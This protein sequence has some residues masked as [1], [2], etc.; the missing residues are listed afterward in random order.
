MTDNETV[1][2]ST[3]EHTACAAI[4]V[5]VPDATEEG[6]YQHSRAYHLF[7]GSRTDETRGIMN[8]GT[9]SAVK[10]SSIWVGTRIFGARSADQ[11]K[12]ADIDVRYKGR[13]VT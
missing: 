8:N 1:P 6:F 7:T 11:A 3:E 5:F 4:R 9:F 10:V 12:Q 2:R 13:L